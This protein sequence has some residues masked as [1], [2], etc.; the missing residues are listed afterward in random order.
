[1]ASYI[2]GSLFT[3]AAIR[4]VL[5]LAALG[6]DCGMQAVLVAVGGVFGCGMRTLSGCT[7]DLVS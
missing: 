6:L 3:N 1:M 5:Y 7:W 4:E 2:A